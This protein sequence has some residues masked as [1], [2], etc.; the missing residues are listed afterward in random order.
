M[1]NKDIVD[2]AFNNPQSP[3]FSFRNVANAS[4]SINASDINEVEYII[5][6]MKCEQFV[7]DKMTYTN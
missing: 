1:I 4:Y 5:E 3:Y 7:R 6:Q 2:D